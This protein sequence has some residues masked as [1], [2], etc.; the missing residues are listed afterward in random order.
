MMNLFRYVFLTGVILFSCVM[1]S[2]K[3]I[4]ARLNYRI[5]I[6]DQPTKVETAAAK[7]LANYL[8][9]TY[10]EKI[11]LNGSDAPIL[12]SVGF[13]PETLD[14]TKEKDAFKDS[15]F[16]VF[17]RKRTVLLTG[18]DDPGVRPY[19]GYEEGTLLSVYYFLRQYTGLKIY[20]PDPVHGEKLG[21]DP[22]L[23]LSS[24]DKPQFSFCIR[25][26]SKTFADVTPNAMAIY[27]R[28]QLCNNY[29]WANA[30]AYYT[31]LGK[32]GKR[33]KNQPEM[34]G[35]H[36]GKRQSILYPHHIPCLTN[37]KVKEVVVND[38]LDL[39][40]KKK[41]ETRPV[42]RVFCDAPYRRCEC[43]N[44]AKITTN[45]DYFY[46]FIV[47]VRD[48][49]KKQYPNVRLVLQEKGISHS[50]PPAN[51][52]L[53]GVVVDIATGFPG[54]GDYRRSQPLVRKWKERGALPTMRLY[55][56][57]PKWTDSPLINPHDIAANFKAMKG[58]ALGQRTSDSN[59][60]LPYAFAA[61]TNYVHVNC[62]LNVDA[63]PDELIREFCTFMYPGA[64]KEMIAFYD[65]MEKQQ[66]DLGTWDDPY[67]KCY[68]YKVLAYPQ[69]LLD[70]AAKKCTDP[71]WLNKLRTAFDN[72]R[73]K[74][75][76]LSHLTVNFEKNH[77]LMNQRKAQFLKQYSKPFVFSADKTAT[78]PLCPMIVPLDEIQDSNVAVQ[79]VK[80]RLVFQFTAMEKRVELIHRKAT[81]EK[82]AGIWGDDSFELM[83]AP[84]K[85]EAPYLQL[86]IN[87]NGAVANLWYTGAG[88][89]KPL[90]YPM[91]FWKTSAA[92][93]KDRWTAE[94][95]VPLSMVRK[96]CPEGKG[97]VGIFRTRVLTSPDPLMRSFYS[98]NSGLDAQSPASRNHHHIFRYHSF[99]IK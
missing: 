30:N 56:R 99:I 26:M 91:S 46:G 9:K 65:W 95:S 39:I 16:G 92:V 61:L 64:A 24:A 8:E 93:Y 84:E 25:E 71:F 4:A 33:F 38:V 6:P 22:E 88:S 73:G 43:D 96:I 41:V 1:L 74:A 50:N 94:L 23:K 12:F 87:A 68:S 5:C 76:K 55:A 42:I 89:C 7:E 81:K 29:Y 37:P 58:L 27:A 40:R 57:Y 80:D 63:D 69:S 70:A 19:Y 36:L 32:W 75:K 85:Q 17:C 21:R 62:L 98:A 14:F 28:K 47:S 52:D 44:C 15:G 59:K 11:R 10:T 34:M 82:P 13:A 20:A 2:A 67:L 35:L 60:H 3:E 31:I 66:S 90:L 78:F 53:K 86:V 77:Q 83:I 97:R 18:K 72:F 48:A 79:I 49:V 51:G 45:D 54:K